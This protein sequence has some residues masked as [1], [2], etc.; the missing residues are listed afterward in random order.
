[1]IADDEAGAAP[2][3]RADDGHREAVVLQL[4]AVVADFVCAGEL[5]LEHDTEASDYGLDDLV[6]SET[7]FALRPDEGPE[8][9]M[10]RANLY[11]E[12]GC[13]RKQEEWRRVLYRK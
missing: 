6:G 2:G 1:M 10:G 5:K 13:L 7:R 4:A 12:H 11:M 8:C 9:G 3:L